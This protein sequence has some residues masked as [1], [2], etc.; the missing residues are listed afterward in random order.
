MGHAG[1]HL[2]CLPVLGFRAQLL[3]MA[4][5]IHK[6]LDR[7]TDKFS[8]GPY[9]WFPCRASQAFQLGIKTPMLDRRAYLLA[10][11]L[12][13]LHNRSWNF[14]G[15]LASLKEVIQSRG[16]LPLAQAGPVAAHS[17]AGRAVAMAHQ[18]SRLVRP[19]AEQVRSLANVRPNKVQRTL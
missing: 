10:T 11:G 18:F 2:F 6:R 4:E 17:F 12:R 16:E 9:R 3:P 5:S 13:F 7:F 19:W 14:S 1:L 8:G 15:A